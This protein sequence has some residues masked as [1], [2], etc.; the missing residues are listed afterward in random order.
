MRLPLHHQ[1]DYPGYLVGGARG[2]SNM[3]DD[4]IRVK[5]KVLPLLDDA[6]IDERA[7]VKGEMHSSANEQIGKDSISP[8]SFLNGGLSIRPVAITCTKERT[9]DYE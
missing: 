1:Y 9:H 7:I 3:W 4:P 8:S 2:G 5:E 6:D